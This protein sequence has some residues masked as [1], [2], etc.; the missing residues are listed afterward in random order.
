MRVHRLL[1]DSNVRRSGHAFDFTID[2]SR[3][4]TDQ[5]FVKDSHMV[6]VESCTSV[7]YS[8]YQATFAADSRHPSSLLLTWD[9]PV[10]NVFGQP[11]ALCHLQQFETKGIYGV[12]ADSQYVN[13]HTMGV[14]LQ[15]DTLNMAGTLRF[16]MLQETGGGFVPCQ[17]ITNNA[18]YGARYRFMLVFW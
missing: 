14:Q 11:N 7:S 4:S 3:L 8:E 16:R 18:V 1:V 5:D 15:G 10:A 12:V 17:P 13:K 2:I 6:T 9:K